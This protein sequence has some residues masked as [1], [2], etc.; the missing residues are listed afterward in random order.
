MPLLEPESVKPDLTPTATTRELRVTRTA[1]LKLVLSEELN[2]Y[3]VGQRLRITHSSLGAYLD[4]Q[5]F[6]PNEESVA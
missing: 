4:R 6:M 5:R 3:K 1:V 2:A